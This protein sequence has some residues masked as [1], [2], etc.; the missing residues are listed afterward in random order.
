MFSTENGRLILSHCGIAPEQ[1][2]VYRTFEPVPYRSFSRKTPQAVLFVEN[3]ATYCS[4]LRTAGSAPPVVFGKQFGTVVY[5]GGDRILGQAGGWT[6]EY[7]DKYLTYKENAVFYFGD[8]DRTGISIFLSLEKLLPLRIVP[9]KEAYVRMAEK[10]LEYESREEA[11]KM[12]PEKQLMTGI[13]GFERYFEPHEWDIISG[14]LKKGY[15]VPQEI[16][17]AGDMFL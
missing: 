12:M 3:S 15:L 10:M 7:V 4:I 6:E 16:L 17:T 9:L 13:S 8:L 14:I 5:G 1:L 2:S 11:K